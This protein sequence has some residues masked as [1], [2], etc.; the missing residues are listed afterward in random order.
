MQAEFD[1]KDVRVLKDELSYQGYF[2]VRTLHLQHRLF[3][4]GWS[5][6]LTREVFERGSAVGVLLYDPGQ[7]SVVLVEQFRPGALQTNGVCGD[8]S[9]WLLEIVAGI[10]EEGEHEEEVARREAL[11]EADC[12][13]QELIPMT[14]CYSSP[15]GC[16]EM[17]T[18]FCG[19]VDARNLG[20]V[21]G[22]G[23]EGEDIRVHV[24][25]REQAWATLEAGEILNAHT[26][27]ALQWLQLN[28]ERVQK[29]WR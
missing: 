1:Q 2:Q 5:D 7:D 19:K 21:H 3:A 6:E 9:P 24:L 8:H 13:I 10:V 20:G 4:G 15:G 11:E 12:P 28:W 27:I 25:S 16:S 14:R 23:E 26:V 22:L 17:L 18:Q 29:Q